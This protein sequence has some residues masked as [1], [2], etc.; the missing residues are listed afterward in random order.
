VTIEQDCTLAK[1]QLLTKIFTRLEHLTINLSKEHLESIPRF[2]LSKPSNSI[3]YLSS[4]CVTKPLLNLIGKF[5]ILIDS[6]NLLDNYT[7]KVINQ[8][9]Y[10][11]W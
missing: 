5:R 4:L 2:L 6:E 3:R 9:L 1:I 11:W 7:L 10:L 8:K